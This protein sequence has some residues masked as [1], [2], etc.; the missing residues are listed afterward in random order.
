MNSGMYE[1]ID[2]DFKISAGNVNNMA[3]KRLFLMKL[4]GS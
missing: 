2:T 4:I 1:T 3:W